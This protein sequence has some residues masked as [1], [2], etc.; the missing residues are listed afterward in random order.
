MHESLRLPL[1]KYSKIKMIDI[2]MI[3]TRLLKEMK[4]KI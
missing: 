3:K 1:V 2:E 4:M